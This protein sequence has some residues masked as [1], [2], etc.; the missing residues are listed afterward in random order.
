MKLAKGTQ[1]Y[2]KWSELGRLFVPRGS[3][4][5]FLVLKHQAVWGHQLGKC[6][7]TPPRVR[8]TQVAWLGD[9]ASLL[10]AAP[11]GTTENLSARDKP[12]RL[13]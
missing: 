6:H 4:F 10:Q 2:S 9:T 13:K 1:L 5:S 3:R 11:A 12:S 7:H 8:D